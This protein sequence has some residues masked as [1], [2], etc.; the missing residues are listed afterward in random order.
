MAKS[1]CISTS[2]SQSISGSEDG[3]WL[4]GAAE[5]AGANLI[6]ETDWDLDREGEGTAGKVACGDTGEGA[7]ISR[8]RSSMATSSTAEG[9]P[10]PI[11]MVGGYDVG[12]L[13]SSWRRFDE[14]ADPPAAGT[15]MINEG[16][17]WSPPVLG[18]E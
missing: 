7:R 11:W 17:Q 3:G 9:A 10:S 8:K 4:T 16:H 5:G 15:L 14:H 12:M 1:L 13:S 6:S 2:L 18:G